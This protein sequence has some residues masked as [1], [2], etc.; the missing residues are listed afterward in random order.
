MSD[1]KDGIDTGNSESLLD[2]SKGSKNRS[3]VDPEI[4]PELPG[5]LVHSAF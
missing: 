3:T 4:V 5:K 1:H 2:G